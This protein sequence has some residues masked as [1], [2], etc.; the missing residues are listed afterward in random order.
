MRNLK[1]FRMFE[2]SVENTPHNKPQA[3]PAVWKNFEADLYNAAEKL[4]KMAKYAKEH[5]HKFK[6]YD[7]MDLLNIPKEDCDALYVKL[8]NVAES[9]QKT[10]QLKKLLA[11]FKGDKVVF[12]RS[13]VTFDWIDTLSQA[14]GISILKMKFEDVS[15]V[16]GLGAGA[17]AQ[18]KEISGVS[19][20]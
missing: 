15:E 9:Q 20:R 7:E 17:I 6:D 14:Q 16:C 11:L 5:G 2:S 12:I 3:A 13:L 10:E 8:E 4:H 19:F 18:A 1:T